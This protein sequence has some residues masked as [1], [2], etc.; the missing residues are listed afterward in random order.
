MARNT[1]EGIESL[2]ALAQTGTVGG[3]AA[4]LRL[5]QSAVTKRLQRLQRAVEFRLLERVGRRVQLTEEAQALLEKATPLMVEL[6][7]LSK[8]RAAL[9]L[10]SFS[11]AMAD[12]IAASWGPGVLATALRSLPDISLEMHV[13]RSVLLVENVRLGRYHAGFASGVSA[14]RDLVQYPVVAEPMVLITGVPFSGRSVEKPLITIEPT[15][16]TWR[17]IEPLIRTHHPELLARRRLTVETLIAAVQLAK[18]GFGDAIV[19]L[20]LARE[21]KV[22]A[23]RMRLLKHVERQVTIVTRK[24]VGHTESF[25]RLRRAVEDAARR[26]MQMSR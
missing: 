17:T 26:R 8:P 14:F 18:S 4:R 15:S 12:S 13:H 22:S 3:A 2:A 5:T 7:A 11:I 24:T 9:Q 19:P 23:G 1:L 20:S 6:Q 10:S 16:L 21:M 25:I